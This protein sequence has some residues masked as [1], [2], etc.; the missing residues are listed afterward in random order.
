MEFRKKNSIDK[1][2]LTH[3]FCWVIFIIY[4]VSLVKIVKASQGTHDLV[5]RD[6]VIPYLI[7]I[8]LFYFHALFVLPLCFTGNKKK[9]FLFSILLFAEI[10]IYLVLMGM[11]D[12]RFLSG[13]TDFFS[14]LYSTRISLVRQIWR[15]I[16]FLI[17][18]SAFYLIENSF[19]KEKK[20]KEAENR[21]LLQEK[22]KKDLELKLMASHN[23]FLQAQINP[24]LLFNTL[25][26]IHSEVQ[27]TA[28]VASEAIITLSEM[29]RYS[30][31][32]TKSDGKVELRQ[33]IEQI[34][35]LIHINRF[36]FGEKLC[37]RLNLKGDFESLYVVPLI[38]VPFV[39]NIFKYGELTDPTTPAV[40]DIEGQERILYFKTFNKK[41]TSRVFPSSGIGM[42]N[43][44]T[45]LNAAYPG[46]YSL[47]VEDNECTY[48]INLIIK[49]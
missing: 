42:K 20:L 28:P 3:V 41:R 10:A 29:M 21:V 11:K 14:S 48:S 25:N 16:Y 44:I 32:E 18:S 8:L 45:R 35:N 12:L 33:E 7:N 5:L 19:R 46:Q 13:N 30:L 34:E 17:F 39:E 15:G 6:Y 49:L 4:E 1:R 27:Q 2:I 37:I 40:I 38:L 22:E 23:A 26:F 9:P 43:V 47:T 31:T 24:H 36:R